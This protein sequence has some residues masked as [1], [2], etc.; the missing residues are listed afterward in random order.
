[1]R[2]A[3]LLLTILASITS[4]FAQSELYPQHFDLKE[5]T[6]ADG[7]LKNALEVNARLL[8]RYDADRLLTPFIRQA[9]LTTGRYAGWVE[10]HPSFR[11]WGLSDWSLEGHVER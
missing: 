6:L 1:M 10:R 7:P 2:K 11:N 5:V 9:G 8:L 4:S 3:L